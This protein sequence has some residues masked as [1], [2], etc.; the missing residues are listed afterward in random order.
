MA[1]GGS[2]FRGLKPTATVGGRSATPSAASQDGQSPVGDAGRGEGAG[3]GRDAER[4][5][6]PVRL[7]RRGG[8]AQVVRRHAASV[9]IQ[10][11][12]A[13][14]AVASPIPTPC[15]PGVEDAAIFRSSDGG[16]TWKELPGLRGAKGHLW[17][18]GAGGMACTRSCCDPQNPNR[19]YI[20]ISAAGAFRTDD[21]GRTWRPINQG[22]KSQY[23]LPDPDAEV[24]PLR[25]SH[26]AASV[27]A[28]RAVHAEALGRDADATTRAT[29]DRGERQPAERLRLSDRRAR[30]RARDDLRGADQERLGALPAGRPKLRVYRSRTG[31]NEWEAL[32]QGAAAARTAT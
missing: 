16:R 24:G 13:S 2:R 14:G 4:R 20:A 29:V 30:A 26:R 27:A 5:E 23:E 17:Q 11:G 1:R 9:G 28:R 7:R 31:G 18:P 6:Q 8:D 3:S 21:G 10:A 32:D 19:I 25:A 15:T 22:L 12:L